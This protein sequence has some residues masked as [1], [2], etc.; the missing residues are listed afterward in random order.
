MRRRT[1]AP[2]S[3][4]SSSVFTT[5]WAPAS[6]AC[7]AASSTSAWACGEQNKEHLFEV[8]GYIGGLSYTPSAALLHPSPR[9]VF[10]VFSCVLAV[11]WAA[12]LLWLRW[13]TRDERRQR[14]LAAQ[15]VL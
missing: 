10:I 2:R 12:V 13:A 14:R 11:G 9:Y 6:A 15:V 8:L 1:C 7:R 4:L 3:S 5:A